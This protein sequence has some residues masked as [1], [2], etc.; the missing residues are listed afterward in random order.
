M[1]I[2]DFEENNNQFDTNDQAFSTENEELKR[3]EEA[4]K[5]EQKDSYAFLGKWLWYYFILII[6][7]I[8][9]A[10]FGAFTDNPIMVLA[11]SIM[12]IAVS[13]LTILILVKLGSQNAKY[14]KAGL[15]Q[16]PLIITNLIKV[17]A[18][19]AT[20]TE[21]PLWY[22]GGIEFVAALVG[23][24]GTYLEFKAHEEVTSFVD[25]TLSETWAKLWKWTVICMVVT[26]CSAFLILIP[27]LGLLI[28]I[29]GVIGLV[30]VSILKLIYLYRTAK[31][32][33]SLAL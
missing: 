9:A 20:E 4:K 16:I 15:L 19:V 14:G 30:V 13:V 7:S 6:P 11:G 17:F 31:L 18:F 28:M 33:Q 22:T 5:A 21:V 32:F 3:Q 12:D 27:V 1:G 8:V 2:N 24:Y 29:A 26:I 25:P 10:V 23:L